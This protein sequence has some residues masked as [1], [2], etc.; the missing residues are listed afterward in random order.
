MNMNP[1]YFK[2]IP[3]EILRYKILPYFREKEYF[4]KSIDYM[5]TLIA[6]DIRGSWRGGC[7]D[8]IDA[9]I[10]LLEKKYDEESEELIE[11]LKESREDINYDGRYIKHYSFYDFTDDNYDFDLDRDLYYKYC[12][13]VLHNSDL[14]IPWYESDGDSD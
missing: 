12:K 5:I 2:K 10:E 6:Q 11:E 3:E 1:D 7:D 8:R 4:S 9:I 14:A 13:Y